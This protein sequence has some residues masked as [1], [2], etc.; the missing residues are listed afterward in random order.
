M[1]VPGVTTQDR[2]P[3]RVLNAVLG[4]TSGRLFSEIRDRR[5]LA[6]S[7]YSSVSQ[8]VDGGIFLGLRRHR[9]RAPP[10]PSWTC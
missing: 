1:P 10:T 6:Y 4:R 8:F 9:R 5:G 7:A 2:A 3:L